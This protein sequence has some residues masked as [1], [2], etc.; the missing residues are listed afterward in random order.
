MMALLIAMLVCVMVPLFTRTWRM[1]F[2]MLGLQGLLLAMIASLQLGAHADIASYVLL[3]DVLILRGLF[4]PIFLQ[5]MVAD[6]ARSHELA[7]IPSNL[8]FW[9]LA[10]VIV[11]AS[12]WFGAKIPPGD[13]LPSLHLG[14][15]LSAVFLSLFVLSM[16][17]RPIGQVIA[18]ITLENGVVLLEL[19]LEHHVSLPVELAIVIVFFLSIITFGVLL[20]RLED[21]PEPAESP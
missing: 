8:V 12:L 20:R 10:I 4:V 16:Q 1:M 13:T 17:T 11:I 5:R 19:L 21:T 3:A 2:R 14:V 18:A 9:G 15:A 7:L 6:R